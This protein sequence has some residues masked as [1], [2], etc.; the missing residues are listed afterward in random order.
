MDFLLTLIFGASE[1]VDNVAVEDVE[2]TDDD[3]SG[4][5]NKNCVIA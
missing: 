1:P 2:I 4:G 3:T 5:G